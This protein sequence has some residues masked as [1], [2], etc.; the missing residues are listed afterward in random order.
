MR[1]DSEHAQRNEIN[2]E[3]DQKALCN[4]AAHSN[5]ANEVANGP[6]DAITF[7]LSVKLAVSEEVSEVFLRFVVSPGALRPSKA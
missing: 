6:A 7:A 2:A 4:E 3:G 5:G 1:D